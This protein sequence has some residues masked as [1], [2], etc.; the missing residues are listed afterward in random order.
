MDNIV[1]DKTENQWV[2][3][4]EDFTD[5]KEF[6]QVLR[7]KNTAHAVEVLAYDHFHSVCQKQHPQ[8]EKDFMTLW[9]SAVVSGATFNETE[10]ARRKFL[11]S[12]YKEEIQA[13]C[14]KLYKDLLEDLSKRISEGAN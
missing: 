13:M 7:E 9:G 2:L 8:K 10:T 12:F 14:A 3:K 5:G 4:A 1:K 6:P 11:D